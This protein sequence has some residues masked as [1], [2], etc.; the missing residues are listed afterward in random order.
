M[1]ERWNSYT[2]TDGF[3][4]VN[5]NSFNHYSFGAVHEWVVTE[6]AGIHFT[7]PG[8]KSLRFQ[9]IPDARI[10]EL[11]CRL[12]TPYGEVSSHWKLTAPGRLRWEITTP[13]NTICQIL[14]PKSWCSSLG[15]CGSHSNGHFV[16]E[17]YL[18]SK[19]NGNEEWNVDCL[20]RKGCQSKYM[21]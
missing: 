21:C 10:G 13:P 18:A 20:G 2:K 11:A 5:M 7:E 14:P 16:F 17:F 15:R 4:D 3:G 1:W 9:C 12:K 19:Q 8:G 6:V